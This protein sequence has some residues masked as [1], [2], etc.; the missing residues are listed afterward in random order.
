MDCTHCSKQLSMIGISVYKGAVEAYSSRV[1]QSNK[2]LIK[3]IIV[4]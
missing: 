3:I 4:P 1:K 2:T